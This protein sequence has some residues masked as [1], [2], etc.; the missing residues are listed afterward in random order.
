MRRTGCLKDSTTSATKEAALEDVTVRIGLLMEAVESQRA[1]ASAALEQLR[2]DLAGLD[3]VV[4][5]Q[6]RATL[7]EELHTLAAEGDRTVLSLRSAARAANLRLAVW[8]A[9]VS[10]V[11]V[12]VPLGLSLWLLPTRADV[13]GLRSTRD[14]LAANVVRLA[15]QGGR[16]QLR[17]C[18]ATQRLCVRIDRSAP[19]YG[20]GADYLVIK[21]Y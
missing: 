5:D 3:A 7:A 16:A 8:T 6:I 18:G 20:E 15:Q 10:T 9:T 4:R 19:A 11:A 21:G 2:A 1:L 12:A 17:R 13:A 14:E